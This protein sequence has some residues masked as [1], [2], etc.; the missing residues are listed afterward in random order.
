MPR[1]ALITGV[2]GQDG[3][4]LSKMLLEK[5]YTVYGTYNEEHSPNRWRLS[6]LDILDRVTLLPIKLTDYAGI[7]NILNLVKPDELYNLAAQS[8]VG[9]SFADPMYTCEI[10]AIGV[11]RLIEAIREINPGIRFYQ[12]SSSELFGLVMENPQTEN[13]PFHPRSPY[14]AAKAFSHYITL[15]YREAYNLHASSGI[16]YNHESP[17]R[18]SEYVTRKITIGLAKIFQNK[19]DSLELGNINVSRD[20]GHARDYVTAMWL[21]LQQERPDDY[22]IATGESHSIKEFI[23]IAAAGIGMSIEWDGE[24]LHEVAY[25]RNTGNQIIRINKLLYRPADVEYVRGNPKKAK[26]ILHWTPT[27]KFESLVNEMMQTDMDRV[28]QNK[29]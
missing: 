24:G 18:G 15:N 22:V 26:D 6:E 4:Y 23:E 8:S 25:N 3:A 7:C 29:I 5:G 20:W 2:T 13:T 14:S 10:N 17:L 1:T 27:I 19:L 28:T 11:L 16:L 21:M 12:A 9:K